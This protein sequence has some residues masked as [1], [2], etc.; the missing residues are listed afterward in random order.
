MTGSDFDEISRA[1][2]DASDSASQWAGDHGTIQVPLPLVT[3]TMPVTAAPRP[4]CRRI[5]C[6][7]RRTILDAAA[8]FRGYQSQLLRRQAAQ[9]GLIADRDTRD[10]LQ[11][12]NDVDLAA[13]LTFDLIL[14][15]P[16]I[17]LSSRA[18]FSS[19]C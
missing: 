9:T 3:H 14:I 19:H 1:I 11:G 5:R 2:P 4:F 6:P 12:L 7:D 10:F 17:S 13:H 16:L 8:K 18:E 15:S